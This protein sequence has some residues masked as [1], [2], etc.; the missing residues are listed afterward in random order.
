MNKDTHLLAEAY[1]VIKE[2]QLAGFGII[3][4]SPQGDKIEIN[5]DVLFQFGTSEFVPGGE[6]KLME[7]ASKLKQAQT[8]IS[9]NT[10]IKVIGHTDAYELKPGVN[11][12]LSQERAKKVQNLLQKSGINFPIS[13]EGAGARNL[14]VPLQ[15]P[16]KDQKAPEEG[17]KQQQPNRR[18]ELAFNP[19][20]GPVINQI[21]PPTTTPQ[22][23][24]ISFGIAGP[25]AKLS[26][27]DERIN[28]EWM[29]RKK[30]Q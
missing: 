1:S 27:E 30:N 24:Y 8:S 19:P 14:K 6:Q 13:A 3:T 15:Y 23:K 20:L 16:I 28:R 26:P 9:P 12:A 18:V 10:K 11:Q 22:N 29:N 7:I 17:R 25:G 21:A 2:Q 5:D 4:A